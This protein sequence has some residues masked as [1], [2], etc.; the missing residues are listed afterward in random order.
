MAKLCKVTLNKETFLANCGD[1]LLDS[2]I[3][4]GVELP[5][6]CRTG[7]CGTCRVR[8]VEGKVFGGDENG[9]DMIHACQARVVSDLEIVTEPVPDQTTMSARV[10]DLVR[11]APD[12][13]GVSLELPSPLHHLPG[14][15]CKVQFRGFPARSY[16]P[17]YP[18]QGGP[19]D[20]Q[21]HFQIRSF[22]DGTVS[23]ALGNK[24][25]PGHR[26]RLTGPYGSAFLRPNH[27]GSTVL[28]SSGTG[29]APMWS[30]AVAAITERPQRDLVFVVAARKLQSF[31]MHNALCR[32]A[33]FPNVT[34]VPIVSEPQNVSHAFRYGRPTDHLPNLSPRDVVYASGAPAMTDSVAR[35]AN[36]A[37]AQC[38]TDP[39]VSH[40]HAGEQSNL[41]A[42]LAGWLDHP[43]A[44]SPELQPAL[45][46]APAIPRKRAPK[47]SLAPNAR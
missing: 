19:S 27:S 14:Q 15:Y 35:L 13:F 23:S 9:S 22:P 33:L 34:I 12:V 45:K 26:V 39:F 17:S 37:G 11:L 24:I 28:V 1:L 7:V 8:R 43:R 30:I 18:L 42:R 41:M 3:M 5:H 10:T 21:L 40:G 4:N 16:S 20:R 44:R 2:A 6:D 47:L 25:R 46:P 38:Y 31:Y 29:F 32:L 36:A